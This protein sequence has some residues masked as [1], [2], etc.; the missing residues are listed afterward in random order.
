LE[1]F[2]GRFEVIRQVGAGAYFDAFRAFD[3]VLRRSVFIKKSRVSTDATVSAIVEAH[4][5]Q[6]KALARTNLNGL[7]KIY[8]VFQEYD[9]WFLVTEWIESPSLRALVPGIIAE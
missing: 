5:H 9:S 3:S 4:L 6:W 1:T 8:D 2:K 7:P